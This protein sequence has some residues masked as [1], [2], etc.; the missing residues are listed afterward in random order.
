MLMGD[1]RGKQL[2]VCGPGELKLK[3]TSDRACRA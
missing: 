1:I 2:R 3:E